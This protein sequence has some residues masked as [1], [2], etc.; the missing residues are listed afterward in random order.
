MKTKYTLITS[1]S[2]H[3]EIDQVT[4]FGISMP[5]QFECKFTTEWDVDELI[6]HLYSEDCKFTVSDD[7]N[8]MVGG[9]WHDALFKEVEESVR[10]LIYRFG[11]T[12]LPDGD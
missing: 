10:T 5:C 4:A 2:F 6:I 12:P 3:A 11:I 9:A 8:V 7:H 1:D